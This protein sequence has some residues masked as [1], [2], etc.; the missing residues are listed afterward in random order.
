[1]QGIAWQRNVHEIFKKA[2]VELS[3]GTMGIESWCLWL[4]L[5]FW[6]FAIL[7]LIFYFAC[8]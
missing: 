3:L 5:F 7:H 1:M 4:V 8:V 6:S 2:L